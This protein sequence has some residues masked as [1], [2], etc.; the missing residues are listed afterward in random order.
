MEKVVEMKLVRPIVGMIKFDGVTR[1][2][3]VP[4]DS[5]VLF[6]VKEKNSDVKDKK[7]LQN[8]MSKCVKELGDDG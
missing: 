4:R 8:L 5:V 1:L 7:E 2:V 3:G 6:G